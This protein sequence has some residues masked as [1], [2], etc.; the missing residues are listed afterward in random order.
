MKPTAV[1]FRV[2]VLFYFQTKNINLLIAKISFRN[3]S[4]VA[5]GK[6]AAWHYKRTVQLVLR[7]F[8]EK[9]LPS[10]KPQ[11]FRC[12]DGYK[13]VLEKSKL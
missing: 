8:F 2:V 7:N 9:V 12:H 10:I 1:A 4:C 5:D 6:L 13:S 3:R 11:S